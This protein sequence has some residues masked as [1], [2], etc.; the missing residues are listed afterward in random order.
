MISVVEDLPALRISE[1]PNARDA[2]G[3]NPA[4]VDVELRTRQG[5]VVVPVQLELV[6][7][8]RGG[9]RTWWRCP[10]CGARRGVLH[11]V[12]MASGP[13]LGCR[14]CFGLA[15]ASQRLS[16]AQRRSMKVPSAS[17]A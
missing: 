7:Q 5:H 8:W 13:Q 9:H 2:Q 12:A 14:G 10:R 17:M 3:S 6:P 4:V 16:R 15:Y 1:R 11:A